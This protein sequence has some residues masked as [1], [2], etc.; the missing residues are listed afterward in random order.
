MK[1]LWYYINYVWRVFATGLSFATFGI[2][3]LLLGYIIM[4]IINHVGLDI[5]RKHLRAQHAVSIFFKGFVLMMQS[6]GLA[7]FTFHDFEKLVQCK[8]HLILSNH[9]TLIDYVL[10]VSRLKSC[11]VVVKESLLNNFFMKKI[12]QSCGYVQ[13]KQS[14]QT[15]EEIK[16]L[17]DAG[18][19]FLIFP[20]GTRTTEGQPIALQ[21][22]SANIAIR[23][24]V[25]IVLVHIKCTKS[26]LD[27]QGKWYNVPQKKVKYDIRVGKKIN[28]SDF[29]TGNIPPSIAT[30]HLTRYIADELEKGMKRN[31]EPNI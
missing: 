8:S 31:D 27:K 30:R 4:P 5:S 12:I 21:R 28:P 16:K 24:N 20:E 6:L 10:I 18:N 3:G 9:P 22:G 26:C 2:G 19:N 15:A 13:N 17:L 1:R 11:Q 7:E 23:V 25:P 29:L 14:M